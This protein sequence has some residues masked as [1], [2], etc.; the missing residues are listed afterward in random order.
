ML[1]TEAAQLAGV[2]GA[3]PVMGRPTCALLPAAI[4]SQSVVAS[5]GCVGNRAYT[6]AAENE[7]YIAIPGA[8]LGAL[9]DSLR[10]ILNANDALEVF[11]R[12]RVSIEW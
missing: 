6:G 12:G 9:V 7:A 2:A 1:V 10:T 11:H 4:E 5:F 3:G 8:H